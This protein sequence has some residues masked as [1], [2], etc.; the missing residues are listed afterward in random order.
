MRHALWAPLR[1]AVGSA[2]K[3]LAGEAGAEAAAVAPGPGL[4]LQLVPKL[5]GLLGLGLGLGLA[6]A[7]AVGA[8]A[9]ALAGASAGAL[10]GASAGAAAGA[11][12]ASAAGFAGAAGAE[13]LLA[14][15]LPWLEPL[16]G[17][18]FAAAL[19]SAHLP[20]N[21]AANAR[22]KNKSWY[23]CC[24]RKSK[25]VG[26]DVASA[27]AKVGTAACCKRKKQ[28]LV[29]MLQTAPPGV[30]NTPNSAKSVKTSSTRFRDWC[31]AASSKLASGSAG[32]PRQA[33]WL[34]VRRARRGRPAERQEGG[35]HRRAARHDARVIAGRARPLDG[36]VSRLRGGRSSP[37]AP[38]SGAERLPP[39]SGARPATTRP[40]SWRS[41]KGDRQP[42]RHGPCRTRPWR[43]SRLARL[44]PAEL[45]SRK[46]AALM[47][48]HVQHCATTKRG[49][50]KSEGACKCKCNCVAA[51]RHKEKSNLQK[52]SAKAIR[53]SNLQKQHADN[54]SERMQSALLSHQRRPRIPSQKHYRLRAISRKGLLLRM[55]LQQADRLA[56]LAKTAAPRLQ[57]QTGVA[58]EFAARFTQVIQL[59]TTPQ[60][61]QG[62]R[63][64][65]WLR[66][67]RR[68]A[69][70][71]LLREGI[72]SSGR[73]RCEPRNWRKPSRLW[74]GP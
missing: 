56:K 69:S 14:P 42:R 32:S 52:Q 73:R 47:H 68:H 61:L 67:G 28:K 31:S 58:L 16:T 9:G 12:A 11:L 65:L 53:K 3:A 26:N 51:T 2:A 37:C 29:M 64:F 4:V 22:S 27:K 72:R 1:G 62:A 36:G 49:K 70:R 17:R 30:G 10:A 71:A 34:A 60:A 7:L 8:S 5:L 41:P 74:C 54:Q 23:C 20:G 38:R 50:R 33:T 13:A 18:R 6:P 57:V 35:C 59:R 40:R 19:P 48:V 15:R 25:T 63:L 24:K 39:A 45:T 46:A 55:N 66:A 44:K 21:E 43:A